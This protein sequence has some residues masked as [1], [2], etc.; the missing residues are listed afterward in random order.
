MALAGLP[1]TTV[2]SGTSFIT[3]APDAVTALCPKVI[4]IL[5]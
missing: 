4:E 5:F 3:T 2:L 1:P